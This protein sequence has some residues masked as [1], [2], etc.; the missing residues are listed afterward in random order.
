MTALAATTVL[1]T[2]GFAW[3]TLRDLQRGL[4]T[5]NALGD[6]AAAPGA[7]MNILLIGL[8]SRRD[9]QG[10]PLP[11]EVLDQL[12]AG[13][14][15]NGGYNTNTLILI[16]VPAGGGKARAFS[17]TRDSYVDVPGEGK[18]K[19]KEAYGLAKFRT[20]QRL[21][22]QGVEDQATVEREGR[23]AGRKA[24]LTVVRNLTGVPINH[25]AEVNLAGFYQ[26]ATALGGVEVCLNNPV[27]D[28]FS[29]ANFPAGKQTLGGAQ[30]L[31]FVRQRHGLTNGDID[32]THRQ[33]AFLASVAHKLRD[34]GAF[35]NPATLQRLLD[36]AKQ[37]VVID[38]GWDLLSFARQAQNLSGGNMFFE[39][40]PIEGFAKINGQDVNLVNP[41]KTRKIVREAF[42]EKVGDKA[43]PTQGPGAA[44]ALQ[45]GTGAPG[46]NTTGVVEPNAAVAGPT[47]SDSEGEVVKV[48]GIPCV[49]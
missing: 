8:D 42:G 41:D 48:D 1:A 32:R 5:S 23:E 6:A 38:R 46:G 19:I 27:H 31:A 4:L 14:S 35:T 16:H 18:R 33:Q 36:V 34:Q 49:D 7:P 28:S 15:D 47:T 11:R 43:A 37:Y 40:L 17:I 26:L 25:F 10:R 44:P 2:T 30:A 22:A 3:A 12:H 13:T 39:T 21:M 29:G 20:E 45:P 9:Q 24:T